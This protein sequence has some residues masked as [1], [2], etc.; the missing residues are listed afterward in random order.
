M[1]HKF[2]PAAKHELRERVEARFR[3]RGSLRFHL[4]LVACALSILL[5]NAV[6]LWVLLGELQGISGAFVR[7]RDSVGALIVLSTSAAL[8][9][10]HYYYRH[11]RGRERQE[12]ETERRIREQLRGAAADEF[13]EQEALVRLQMTEKL[14]NRRLVLWHLALFLGVMSMFVFVHPMNTRS[15]F[16]PDPDIW[17]G[18]LTVA[19]VWGIGLAAHIT[20]YVFAYRLPG[21]RREAQIEQQ[22]EREL[23]RERRQRQSAAAM[24]SDNQLADAAASGGDEISIEDLLRGQSPAQRASRQ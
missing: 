18:P 22:L 1:K 12:A 19:G 10:I 24:A 7:Y 9:A 11:G 15:L 3:A 23:R 16:R 5:F 21:G 8:H 2:K 4:L 14:K 20:R 13:E 17:Q 6:D